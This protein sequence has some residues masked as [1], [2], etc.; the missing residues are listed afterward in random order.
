VIHS[1][2][3]LRFVVHQGYIMKLKYCYTCMIYRPPRA[4]HCDDC[5]CCIMRLDHH[6]P[7]LGTCVGQRNYRFFLLFVNTLAVMIIYIVVWSFIFLSIEGNKITS[8]EH[9]AVVCLM[10]YSLLFSLF[11]FLLCGYHHYLVFLNNTTNENIKGTYKVLGNPFRK[12][13]C[14]HLSSVFTWKSLSKLWNNM[15]RAKSEQEVERAYNLSQKHVFSKYQGLPSHLQ[16]QDLIKP[17]KARKY[18]E[19]DEN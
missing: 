2:Y 17:K 18:F 13:Y 11:V 9:I 3:E 12:N 8:K 16:C 14:T 5:G 15:E 4:I 6:C 10:C 19:P 7:W 1:K